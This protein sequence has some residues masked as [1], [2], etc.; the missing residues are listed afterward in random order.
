MTVASPWFESTGF[1][2]L[3]YLYPAMQS[4]YNGLAGA[5]LFCN[6]VEAGFHTFLN[7]CVRFVALRWRATRDQRRGHYHYRQQGDARSILLHQSVLCTIA[8]AELCAAFAEKNSMP[9]Y[10]KAAVATKTQK[11]HVKNIPNRVIM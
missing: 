6:S 1:N 7:R 3:M 5:F 11:Y 2:D 4:S 10:P 8:V 9:K